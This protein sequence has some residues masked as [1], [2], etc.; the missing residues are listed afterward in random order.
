MWSHIKYEGSCFWSIVDLERMTDNGLVIVAHW[1]AITRKQG[2]VART[3]GSVE[4]PEKDPSDP[5]FIAFDELK[6]PE[7][8]D[9]VKTALGQD[10]VEEIEAMLKVKAEEMANPSKV[11]GTPWSSK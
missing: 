9:W 8:I 6:E 11:S 2:K 4:L 5:R 3:Y 10:R 1:E 7:V